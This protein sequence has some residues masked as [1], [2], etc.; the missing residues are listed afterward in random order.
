MDIS[1]FARSIEGLSTNTIRN[2][3]STLWQL[4]EKIAGSEPTNPEIEQFLKSFSA[5]SMHRHRAAVKAYLEY[6]GIQWPFNARVFRAPRP[7]VIR[8]VSTDIVQKMIKVA[9]INSNDA[10]FILTLFTLGCRIT[11]IRSIKAEDI[12]T[13]GVTMYT[14]GGKLQFKPITRTFA[15]TLAKYAN[16]KKGPIFPGSYDYYRKKILDLGGKVGEYVTPHMLR[17]ARAVD[18]LKSGMSLPF[19][20]QF[21][22][23]AEIDTTAR[24]LQV[25]GGELARQLEA[26]DRMDERYYDMKRLGGKNG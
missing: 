10:M 6:K 26:V 14:K 19:V 18:L 12:K 11:E 13:D 8:Y 7:V 1:G 21:L 24:Y 3:R 2:Y 4:N 5:N 9:G 25:T 20:Q 16:G 17:H 15:E 23:H 22:G